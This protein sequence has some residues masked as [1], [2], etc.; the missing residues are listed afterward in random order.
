MSGKPSW[1]LLLAALSAACKSGVTEPADAKVR[2]DVSATRALARVGDI[3]E[4]TVTARN[5]GTST[6]SWTSG[7]GLDLSY[8]IVTAVEEVAIDG[9][10]FSNACTEELRQERL[11]PNE[12]MQRVIL[13]RVGSLHAPGRQLLPA[14]Y[15]V[16]GRLGVLDTRE[17]RGNQV[18]FA[19]VP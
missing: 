15:L 17:R 9:P 4:L 19:I 13:W 18:A 11:T 6:V 7:C 12:T 8:E 2:L 10:A 16:R 14:R 5:E 3:V 1:L